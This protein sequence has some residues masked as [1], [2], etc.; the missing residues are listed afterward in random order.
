MTLL[1]F[2]SSCVG[3]LLSPLYLS[4]P[5]AMSIAWKWLTSSLSSSALWILSLP[6]PPPLPDLP[7]HPGW[8]GLVL[9]DRNW[10]LVSL[11]FWLH[12]SAIG[13]L[14][15]WW[16]WHFGFV[17]LQC[18]QCLICTACCAVSNLTVHVGCLDLTN[19]DSSSAGHLSTLVLNNE[20]KNKDVPLI[21]SFT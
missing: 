15:S 7:H 16:Q 3:V 5:V 13:F 2:L 12:V 11:G 10:T 20:G 8:R 19:M 4:S 1:R 14:F 17:I 21:S 9:P 6:S 18:R